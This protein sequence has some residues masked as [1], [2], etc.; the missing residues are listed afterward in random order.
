[1]VQEIPNPHVPNKPNVSPEKVKRKRGRP[2][3]IVTEE[4][5]TVKDQL[6]TKNLTEIVQGKRART[7]S[8]LTKDPYNSS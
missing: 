3:K 7:K 6:S 2:K 5:N 1:M 4:T 8:H